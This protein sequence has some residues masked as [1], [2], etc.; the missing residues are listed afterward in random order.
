MAKKSEAGAQTAVRL[1]PEMLR[2]A[3]A[4]VSKMAKDPTLSALGRVT[5]STVLKIAV[6]RGLQALE[7]QYK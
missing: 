1:P 4:L 7:Q 2:R 5:R 6:A 3:E